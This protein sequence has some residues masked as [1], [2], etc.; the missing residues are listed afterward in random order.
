MVHKT[1]KNLVKLVKSTLTRISDLEEKMDD[2][3]GTSV[4]TQSKKKS[5]NAPLNVRVR[6]FTIIIYYLSHNT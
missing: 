4:K 6:N 2:I 5:T 3:R 1:N